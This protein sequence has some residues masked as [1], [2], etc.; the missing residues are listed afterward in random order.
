MFRPCKATTATNMGYRATCYTGCGF[1]IEE[2][3]DYSELRGGKWCYGYVIWMPIINKIISRYN[4]DVHVLTKDNIP[5]YLFAQ[6]IMI[7]IPWIQYK[8]YCLRGGELVKG[9]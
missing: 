4:Y 9:A 6:Y 8:W 5:K 2:E 3:Y 1:I 7:I